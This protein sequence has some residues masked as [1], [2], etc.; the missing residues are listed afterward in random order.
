M[1]WFQENPPDKG[2]EGLTQEALAAPSEAGLELL[3]PRPPPAG[4]PGAPGGDGRPQAFPGDHA[5][6][7]R[8]GVALEN[9]RRSWAAIE[10]LNSGCPLKWGRA[11]VPERAAGGRE[12]GDL[13]TRAHVWVP[14]CEPPGC[15]ES[16]RACPPLNSGRRF[17][18]PPPHACLFWSLL[19][20]RVTGRGPGTPPLRA[21]ARGSLCFWVTA[22]PTCTR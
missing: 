5:A 17:G 22:D 18:P 13:P 14:G 2:M 3:S 4:T 20:T 9:G 15:G 16:G 12:M 7:N 1:K 19:G 10:V 6:E 11:G 8:A 21:A